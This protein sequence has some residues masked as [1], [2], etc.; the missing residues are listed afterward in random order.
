VA[1]NGHIDAICPLAISARRRTVFAFRE[2]LVYL[3]AMAI[4]LWE[5]SPP[6]RLRRYREEAAEARRN[7]TKSSVDRASYLDIAGRWDSLADQLEKS[8]AGV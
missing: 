6:D 5:L 1:P 8:I 3:S 2:K 4:E 7:A